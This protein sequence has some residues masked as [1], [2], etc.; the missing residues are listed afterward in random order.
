MFRLWLWNQLLLNGR[1]N[2]KAF[3]W[4]E[5]STVDEKVKAFQGHT[6]ISTCLFSSQLSLLLLSVYDSLVKAAS[7]VISYPGITPTSARV[8]RKR[9]NGSN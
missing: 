1:E 4:A 2:P 7:G 3:S 6:E 8:W 5:V 9:N